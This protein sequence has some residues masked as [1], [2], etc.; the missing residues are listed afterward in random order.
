MYIFHLSDPKH[1]GC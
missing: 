1:T